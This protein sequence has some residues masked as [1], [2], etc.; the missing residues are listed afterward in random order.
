MKIRY[1]IKQI[2]KRIIN[3][4]RDFH[5][6]PELS[7]KENRTANVIEK[8]LKLMGLNPKINPETR[9]IFSGVGIRNKRRLLF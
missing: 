5:Q 1:E 9:S 7:F 4:R 6:Y 8:E 3:W 2:E